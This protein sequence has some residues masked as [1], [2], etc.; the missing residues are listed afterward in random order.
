MKKFVVLISILIFMSV[1]FIGLKMALDLLQPMNSEAK[2][3]LFEVKPGES[4]STISQRL[5]SNN[6]IRDDRLLKI[7]AR[8]TGQAGNVRVGEYEL[9]AAMAPLK[10][11]SIITSGKSV[12]HRVTFQ[13]G[14][15]MYEVAEIL[16]ERGLA[17]K[18]EFLNLCQDGDFIHSL[19]KERLP[20]LEGY[21]F[22]ETYQFTKYTG[23]RKIIKTMVD[24]FLKVYEEEIPENRN[25]Y[26][27]KHEIVTLASIIE[28]E[29]G[30]PDERPRI[31]SVFHNRL[32]KKMRLQSDPTI[33][34][35][36]LVKTGKMLKNI[37]RSHIREHTKY[38]TYTVNALP[39]GPISNPGRESLRAV[40]AP[41]ETDFLYFVS[42]NDGTHY[43]S[44]T[45]K[46]HLQAVRDYQL[47]SKAREGKSW[48]DLKKS[49]GQ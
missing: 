18:G 30:A 46:E 3:E 8:V 38:N 31:A 5:V 21:L 11:M 23:A 37:K 4:F 44:K 17:N 24:R 32:D 49:S 48:R 26:L 10:I 9:S 25:F 14:L 6:F 16:E 33:I 1:T 42:R 27:D 20:S 19:L 34:Y 2:K 35:G 15:N 39:Y 36:V 47:N 29:T 12:M 22:P 28:K 45:Y 40:V 13:E 43:F 7:F 41:E